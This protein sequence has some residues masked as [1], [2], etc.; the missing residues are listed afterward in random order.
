MV[1]KQ[2]L[3]VSLCYITQSDH[4]CFDRFT[5]HKI[6]MRL[7]TDPSR[8]N[9][10]T[11]FGNWG[12]NEFMQLYF[13]KL[14]AVQACARDTLQDDVREPSWSDD[15]F[16]DC[17]LFYLIIWSRY[18]QLPSAVIMRWL[19]V[20]RAALKEPE[21][22]LISGHFNIRT[23]SVHDFLRFSMATHF[24]TANGSF[25][26]LFTALRV[27]CFI[28]YCFLHL[29]PSNTSA[30]FF[31]ASMCWMSFNLWLHPPSNRASR[32]VTMNRPGIYVSKQKLSYIQ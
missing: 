14:F 10:W 1:I 5:S 24:I 6:T 22:C 29:N 18:S 31:K 28:I 9:Y 20:Q 23:L 32:F 21:Q 2:L 7:R 27:T 17:H 13:K 11:W 30:L 4:R 16:L 26:A 12:N 19:H 15:T 25:I 3:H 8:L